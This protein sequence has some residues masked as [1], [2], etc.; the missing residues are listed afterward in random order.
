MKNE[1]KKV[2]EGIPNDTQYPKDRKE[3]VEYRPG[4]PGQDCISCRFFEE[5][6][7]CSK[8]VGQIYRSGTCNLWEADVDA[9]PQGDPDLVGLPAESLEDFMFGGPQ[10]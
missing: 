5:P 9:A 7:G 10:V 8:V 1:A 6:E 4:E 3:T 2:S